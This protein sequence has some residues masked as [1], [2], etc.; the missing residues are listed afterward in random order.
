MKYP[1]TA[2][3]GNA[4]EFFF[5]YQVAK[6]LGWPCRIFDIDIGVDAQ[7]EILDAQCESTGRFVAVQIKTTT[8][9]GVATRYVDPKQL[10]YWKR[11]ESPVF[12]VLV[13]LD[14]ESMYL[15]R[16]DRRKR[17]PKTTSGLFRID[18]DRQQG[19]FGLDSGREFRVAAE[20]AQLQVVNGHLKRVREATKEIMTALGQPESDPNP[21]QL[22][23]LMRERTHAHEHLLRAEAL[24]R[25]SGVG[26]R[27][28]HRCKLDF[29]RALGLLRHRM[30]HWKMERDWDGDR[31]GNGDIGRFLAEGEIVYPDA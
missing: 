15:H 25:N 16:I 19:R 29:E 12:L 9:E 5:A 24:A 13:D 20:E 1:K 30:L 2:A 21:D 22:I 4:G 3:T 23:E 8:G 10:E 26:L 18:F 11:L 7:V 6:V 14:D 27:Q 31:A 17:Y 28:Y